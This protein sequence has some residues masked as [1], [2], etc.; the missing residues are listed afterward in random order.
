M[1]NGGDRKR[2]ELPAPC[3][4]RLLK[5]RG[6][7][8]RDT[9]PTGQ[10]QGRGGRGGAC[11]APGCWVGRCAH[12]PHGPERAP[13]LWGAEWPA[14]VQRPLLPGA[15]RGHALRKIGPASGSPPHTETLP[16]VDTPDPGLP[17]P[18]CPQH[19]LPV[20]APGPPGPWDHPAP[21][22][23]SDC[24]PGGEGKRPLNQT[25]PCSLWKALERAGLASCGAR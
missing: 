16:P 11:P 4:C 8:P 15:G 7:R 6:P 23:Q 19:H 18:L 9:A 21:T 24:S 12:C 2:D 5:K 3:R 22:A 17:L 20:L 25:I 13:S 14:A 1:R 10:G